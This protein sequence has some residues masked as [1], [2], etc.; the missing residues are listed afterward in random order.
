[1]LL[2]FQLMS[3]YFIQRNLLSI[4]VLLRATGQ[5]LS[6]FQM[7]ATL[8]YKIIINKKTVYL[9]GFIKTFLISTMFH[10]N[11]F[12]KLLS[13]K[14]AETRNCRLVSIDCR[15]CMRK[16]IVTEKEFVIILR[17]WRYSYEYQQK[18]WSNVGQIVIFKKYYLKRI[19]NC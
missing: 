7:I 17:W 16:K 6:Q 14:T 3:A 8:A 18:T 11:S 2:S 19:I 10:G 9:T 15:P 1:M 12:S 4:L 13:L 5:I